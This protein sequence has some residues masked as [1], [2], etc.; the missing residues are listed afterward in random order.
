M[1]QR[2]AE[3]HDPTVRVWLGSEVHLAEQGI[4]VLGIPVG[5]DELRAFVVGEDTG[6]ATVLVKRDLHSA[7]RAEC[8]ALALPLRVRSCQL[9]A[10]SG[11]TR[12]G[13]FVR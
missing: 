12:V 7:R 9:P 10:E 2:V 1:L 6:K 3:V 11:K 8:V 4:K 5:H 13:Q